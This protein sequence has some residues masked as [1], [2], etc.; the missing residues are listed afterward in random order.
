MELQPEIVAIY[1]Q[2]DQGCDDGSSTSS[3]VW[4][5]ES[6]SGEAPTGS[7]RCRNSCQRPG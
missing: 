3:A 7:R 1:A 2:D 6:L 5:A 4:M